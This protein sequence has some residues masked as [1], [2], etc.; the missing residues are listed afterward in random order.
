MN[1]EKGIPDDGSS[2]I[3][4][5]LDF[6]LGQQ[7]A[8][9][10]PAIFYRVSENIDLSA[11]MGIE[12]SGD[13]RQTLALI[14]KIAGA[15]QIHVTFSR[16][17]QEFGNKLDSSHVN[18][19]YSHNGFVFKFPIFTYN[20][21]QNNSGLLLSTALFLSANALSYYG[22]TWKNNTVDKE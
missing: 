12:L 1:I 21:A 5:K 14:Y 8:G 2:N 3:G 16:N 4:Y 13:V 9:V 22:M 11:A 7:S 15:K 6:N 18:L 19:V 10:T 20:Q 17:F